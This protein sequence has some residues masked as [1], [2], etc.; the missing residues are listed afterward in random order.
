MK[1]LTSKRNKIVTFFTALCLFFVGIIGAFSFGS[2]KAEEPTN[3]FDMPDISSKKDWET[4]V[5]TENAVVGGK[6]YRVTKD[7][8]Q[9]DGSI[10]AFMPNNATLNNKFNSELVIYYGA[11]TS[12]VSIETLPIGYQDVTYDGVEYVEFYMPEEFSYEATQEETTLEFSYGATSEITNVYADV[13][14]ITYMQ[15]EVIDWLQQMFKMEDKTDRSHWTARE[16]TVG[17]SYAGKYFRFKKPDP[18]VT[19]SLSLFTAYMI[20]NDV[21]TP[22]TVRYKTADD[23]IIFGRYTVEYKSVVYD[24]EI[25]LEFYLPESYNKKVAVRPKLNEVYHDYFDATSSRIGQIKNEVLVLEEPIMDNEP[26]TPPTQEPDGEGDEGSDEEDDQSEEKT[27]CGAFFEDAGAVL[28]EVFKIENTNFTALGIVG[29]V[30]VALVVIM[31]IV[32]FKK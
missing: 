3:V 16:L 5:I 17:E 18:S 15:I 8:I 19:S 1:Q 32:I 4:H 29:I 31:L 7:T 24:D 12:G 14:E 25:Y 23:Q 26:E 11:Y 13:E 6:Y 27:G 10:M 30:A 28:S 20:V 2:V 21:S 9:P 22:Y